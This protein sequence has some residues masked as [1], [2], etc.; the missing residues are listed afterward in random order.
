MEQSTLDA[1]RPRSAFDRSAVC[2]TLLLSSALARDH[3]PAWLLHGG[4]FSTAW[5]WGSLACLWLVLVTLLVSDRLE[6]GRLE[7]AFIGLLGG[8]PCL[9]GLSATWSVA[10]PAAIRELERGLLLLSALVAAMLLARRHM[11]PVLGGVLGG[12]T[13]ACGYGL[14]TRLFPSY[15]GGALRPDRRLSA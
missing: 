2:T 5:G 12:I 7:I 14:S 13:I 15:I 10:A 11:R 4:Y 1:P 8:I 3:W 9:D 6:L